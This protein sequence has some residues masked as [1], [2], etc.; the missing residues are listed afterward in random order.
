MISP[1]VGKA[2]PYI[3]SVVVLLGSAMAGAIWLLMQE[4]DSLNQSVGT[5]EQTNKQY[6]ETIQLNATDYDALQAE[7]QLRDSLVSQALQAQQQAERKANETAERLR[8]ALQNDACANTRHPD[9]VTD[10]LRRQ[11]TGSKDED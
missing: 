2:L 4:R 11:P 1:L 3:I 10:S 9:A 6:T 7:L 8:K 5:L